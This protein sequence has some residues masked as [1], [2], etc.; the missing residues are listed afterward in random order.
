MGVAGAA[1]D[2][3]G[4]LVAGLAGLLAGAFPCV[5]R[6]GA[7]VASSVI[8]SAVALFGTG[9]II[10]VF[11]GVSAWRSGMRQLLMGLAAAGATFGIG[12]LIGIAVMG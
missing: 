10:T 4:T 3:R 1:I 7:A 6:G 5:A 9:G 12:K 8:L 11:T 2:S